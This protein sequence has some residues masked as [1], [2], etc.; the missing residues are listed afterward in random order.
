MSPHLLHLRNHKEGVSCTCTIEACT[1]QRMQT[2]EATTSRHVCS[3]H[4]RLITHKKTATLKGGGTCPLRPPP[5][6]ATELLLY[7]S[8]YIRET[9]SSLADMS[10]V[11]MYAKP[12]TT[13][14]CLFAP[15]AGFHSPKT[16]EKRRCMQ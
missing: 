13:G 8:I 15:N 10:R 7:K 5:K 11:C 1:Y 2:S 3:T 12:G 4:G 6:S 16:K 9:S 14:R